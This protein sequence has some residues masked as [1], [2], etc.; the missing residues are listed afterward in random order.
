[1]T[2]VDKVCVCDVGRVALAR[3]CDCA[4]WARLAQVSCHAHVSAEGLVVAVGDAA[5]TL[6]GD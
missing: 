5:N 4:V 1:M 2:L 6:S 3:K